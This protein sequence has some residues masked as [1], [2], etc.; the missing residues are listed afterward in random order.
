MTVGPQGQAPG[1]RVEKLNGWLGC[2]GIR[3]FGVQSTTE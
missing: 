2:L 3:C 1:G